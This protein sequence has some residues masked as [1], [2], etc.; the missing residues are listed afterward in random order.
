MWEYFDAIVNL[1]D[2]ALERKEVT[3][4]REYYVQGLQMVINYLLETPSEWIFERSKENIGEFILDDGFLFNISYFLENLLDFIIEYVGISQK[5]EE[6][7]ADIDIMIEAVE[8]NSRLSLV[9]E[10]YGSNSEL[11]KKEFISWFQELLDLLQET[12]EDFENH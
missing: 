3:E 8:T 7:K 1:A 6:I 10:D 4:A 9:N 12:S 2:F 11:V 5:V